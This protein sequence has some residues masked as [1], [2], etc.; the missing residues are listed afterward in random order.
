MFSAFRIQQNVFLI[1]IRKANN[2]I[3]KNNLINLQITTSY[4]S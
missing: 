3:N 4:V 2:K 1:T